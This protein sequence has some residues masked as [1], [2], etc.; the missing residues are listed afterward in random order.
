MSTLLCTQRKGRPKKPNEK[1]VCLTTVASY[2]MGWG[3]GGGVKANSL[4]VRTRL[5]RPVSAYARN[6]H[7]IVVFVA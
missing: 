5:K 7:D 4:A 3:V 2:D 6:C 1:Q